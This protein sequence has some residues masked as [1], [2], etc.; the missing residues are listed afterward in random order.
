MVIYLKA[1]NFWDPGDFFFWAI[2]LHQCQATSGLSVTGRWEQEGFCLHSIHG[3]CSSGSLGPYSGVLSIFSLRISPGSSNPWTNHEW[4]PLFGCPQK[5]LNL[6]LKTWSPKQD[7]P[8]GPPTSQQPHW[9]REKGFHTQGHWGPEW[10]WVCSAGCPRSF[11]LPSHQVVFSTAC[12]RREPSMTVSLLAVHCPRGNL[13]TNYRQVTALRTTGLEAPGRQGPC[14][15]H[16]HTLCSAWRGHMHFTATDRDSAGSTKAANQ[17]LSLPFPALPP[18]PDH[19]YSY[20]PEQLA[21]VS[22]K[23]AQGSSRSSTLPLSLAPF[24][25]NPIGPCRVPA[26]LFTF[27]WSKSPLEAAK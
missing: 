2:F 12:C 17:F 13:G 8:T 5:R 1:I 14:L 15:I 9:K 20:T 25:I 16:P 11:P 26:H 10:P 18:Y 27:P 7:G 23:K 24:F 19:C 6:A 21:P 22:R 3:Q 4:D